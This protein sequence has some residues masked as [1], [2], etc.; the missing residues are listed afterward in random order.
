MS[1][2]RPGGFG[3]Q[4]FGLALAG[5]RLHCRLDRAIHAN[6]GQL[7]NRPLRGTELHEK[8]TPRP[9]FMGLGAVHAGLRENLCRRLVADV[10]TPSGDRAC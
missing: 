6:G 4:E 8:A 7:A 10:R 1:E 3:S 2:P 5:S 9:G